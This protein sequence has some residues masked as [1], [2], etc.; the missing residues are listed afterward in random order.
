MTV[1]IIRNKQPRPCAG[2]TAPP[3]V[4]LPND[5][6]AVVERE[7]MEMEGIG[8]GQT[9]TKPATPFR[10]TGRLSGLMQ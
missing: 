9:G 10:E 2:L 6:A 1:E 3:A 8:T 7:I 4:F 5:C